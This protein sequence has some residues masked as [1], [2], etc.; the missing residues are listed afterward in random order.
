MSGLAS[1]DRQSRRQPLRRER[2]QRES[3]RAGGLGAPSGGQARGVGREVR[4]GREGRR[5]HADEKAVAARPGA[6]REAEL[7]WRERRTVSDSGSEALSSRVTRR[8]SPVSGKRNASSSLLF[9]PMS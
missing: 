5:A 3:T 1:P 7:S 8:S 6:S 4:R 9:R 2:R